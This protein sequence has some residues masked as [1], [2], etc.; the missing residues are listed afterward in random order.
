MFDHDVK[1]G[2]RT[3]PPGHVAVDTRVTAALRSFRIVCLS[4]EKLFYSE[5]IF[6]LVNIAIARTW[7]VK[8]G[9]VQLS[10]RLSDAWDDRSVI[11]SRVIEARIA[12]GVIDIGGRAGGFSQPGR[13]CVF[14]SLREA[15]SSEIRR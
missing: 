15:S 1:D 2:T 4:V 13:R 7:T 11:V 10:E 12:R 9:R 6:P 5:A 3:S 8:S 14:P